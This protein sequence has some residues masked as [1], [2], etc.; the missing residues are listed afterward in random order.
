MLFKF[1]TKLSRLFQQACSNNISKNVWSNVNFNF[2]NLPRF[3]NI[4]AELFSIS[5]FKLCSFQVPDYYEIIANPMD[6][7][8]MMSKIDLHK[9]E[10]VDQFLQDIN[11]IVS[12]ALEYN[13]DK[14][15]QGSPDLNIL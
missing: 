15:P 8:M 10:T 3:K 4:G 7:S 13:P 1:E 14:D 12:N 5:Q 11:L 2:S 9:Y 6:L